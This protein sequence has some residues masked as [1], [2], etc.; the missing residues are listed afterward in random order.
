MKEAWIRTNWPIAVAGA[1]VLLAFIGTL[2]PAVSGSVFIIDVSRTYIET[3]DGKVVLAFVLLSGGF[4]CWRAFT[5]HIAART[6]CLIAALVVTGV[7]IFGLVDAT[8]RVADLNRDTVGV[9]SVGAA[10][11]L[12]TVGGLVLIGMAAVS[13]RRNVHEAVLSGSGGEGSVAESAPAHGGQGAALQADSGGAAGTR[14]SRRSRRRR[15]RGRDGGGAGATTPTGGSPPPL[16]EWRWRTMPVFTALSFGLFAGMILGPAITGT[17]IAGTVT[18]LIVAGML[19]YA[20]SRLLTRL[21]MRR[22]VIKPRA[23]R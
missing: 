22:G 2:L 11:Y 1:G 17:G 15:R 5:T 6:G 7:A 10:V 19:G 12:V 21:L 16:P 4:W 13:F 3:N 18:F 9:A 23:R 20:V 14:G 8:Q